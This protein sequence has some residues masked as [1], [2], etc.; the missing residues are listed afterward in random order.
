MGLAPGDQITEVDGKPAGDYTLVSLQSLLFDD[1]VSSIELSIKA[2][3]GE[4]NL[5]IG[6]KCLF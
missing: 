6:K 5:T 2:P 1:A 4:K 3:L